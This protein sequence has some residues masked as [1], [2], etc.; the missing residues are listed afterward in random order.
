MMQIHQNPVPSLCPEAI[1][2]IGARLRRAYA[3][4]AFEGLPRRHVELILALR[5]KER[6]RARR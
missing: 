3:E 1:A 6:E 5:A 4:S 2:G